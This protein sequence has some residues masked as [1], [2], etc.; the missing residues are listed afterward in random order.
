MA[1]DC[2]SCTAC[3]RVYAIPAFNK[4]AGKWCD[5]CDIGKGCK[6]YETRPKH[7]C[8]DFQC[9][10]LEMKSGGNNPA[11]DLRPD[12]CKVVFSPTPRKGLI[13]AT[14]MPGHRDAFRK[15]AARRLIDGLIGSGMQVI[16]GPSLSTTK[17]MIDQ[18]GER[19]IEMTEPDENGIQRSVPS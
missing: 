9:L 6:A 3:C 8:A 2:G 16:V 5:H 19:D 15:G 7:E 11:D 17:I 1:G 4:P 13:S 14:T 18:F 10:W 12:R